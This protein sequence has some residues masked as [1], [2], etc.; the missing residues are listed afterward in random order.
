MMPGIDGYEVQV[1]ASKVRKNE[2]KPAVVMLTSKSGYDR[3]FREVYLAVM[4]TLS[5]PVV[6]G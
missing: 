1:N 2:V 4:P 6:E 5:K 3:Q